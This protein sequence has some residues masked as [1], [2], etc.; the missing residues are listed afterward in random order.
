MARAAYL[1]L[2]A[3]CLGGNQAAVLEPC[4]AGVSDDLNWYT[5]TSSGKVH[6]CAWLRADPDNRC[7]NDG[8]FIN[9]P[10]SYRRPRAEAG[11]S[12]YFYLCIL[13]SRSTYLRL[14]F[15]ARRTGRGRRDSSSRQLLAQLLAR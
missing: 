7:N 6:D 5:T 15:G 10:A 1:V 2:A 4:P 3:A 12:G 14:D 9:C 13:V 8:R 11:L